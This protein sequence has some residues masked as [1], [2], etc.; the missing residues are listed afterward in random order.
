MK[1]AFASFKT[2]TQYVNEDTL[3]RALST[4]FHSDEILKGVRKNIDLKHDLQGKYLEFDF[5]IPKYKLCFEFNDPY[6]Y[7]STWYNQLTAE[8]ISNHDYT[9]K[10]ATHKHGMSLI[11]IPC[12][13]NGAVEWLI[14]TIA[15]HHPDLELP[16]SN[17]SPIHLNPPPG[18]FDKSG[19]PNMGELMLASFPTMSSAV[20][21]HL[22]W[23]GE[24]YDGIRS[25]WDPTTTTLYTRQGLEVELPPCFTSALPP[26]FLD[27]ELWFGRGHYSIA[28]AL[29]SEN[30]VCI[31]LL[32][33]VTF[34]VPDDISRLKYEQ[35]Y[36]ILLQS[37]PPSHPCNHVVSRMDCDSR[38][39]ESFLQMITEES[40]EGL[41]LQMHGSKYE[42]GRSQAVLKL[43]GTKNEQEGIV[44]GF[45]LDHSVVVKLPNNVEFAVPFESV[46]TSALSKGDVVTFSCDNNLRLAAPINPKIF[47]IRTDLLWED[48]VH[49]FQ[50]D[51]Q[52]PSPETFAEP[53]HKKQK[54]YWTLANMRLYMENFAKSKNLDPLKAETWHKQ[55]N[56]FLRLNSSKWIVR[57]FKDRYFSTV[58]RVFPEIAVT[59]LPSLKLY[60]KIENRLKFFESYAA[61]QGFDPLHAESWYQQPKE[62]I[63]AKKGAKG[64]M[65]HYK[66]NLLKGL[67]DI[68]PNI[69]LDRT[70]FNYIQKFWHTAENRRSFFVNYAATKNFD[71]K[72]PK[73][74]YTQQYSSIVSFKGAHGV[75]KY[76]KGLLSQALIDL[77]PDIGLDA[78]KFRIGWRRNK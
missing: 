30:Q 40:G 24:K 17:L 6:H 59:P 77:F 71:P 22:W 4:I 63:L 74:W 62:K 76:Y 45:G 7:T 41:I 8:H 14:S 9:K 18:Y 69:G 78:S 19:I 5:W 43:K 75:L 3:F 34:D 33:M 27:G 68:F 26:I 56:A 10:N 48:V 47:R 73:N 20:S 32:R 72:Q 11:S 16:Q 23:L 44:V 64:V 25:C 54:G 1:E 37:I 58:Q 70:K 65:R 35:R 29:L 49:S 12:W 61:E 66:D 50:H 39:I 42:R 53:T 57:K 28:Q 46:L 2:S 67:L 51:K 13:W 38:K 21:I 55:R 15:F 31:D 60:H 52:I 36:Q